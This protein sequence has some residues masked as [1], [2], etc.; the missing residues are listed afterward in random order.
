MKERPIIFSGAMVRA[1]LDGT[2]TQTRRVIKLRHSWSIEER[3]DGSPWP[4]HLDYVTGGEWDGWAPCPYGRPGDR[5]WVRETW[6]HTADS[7]EDARA[8]T[9]DV[10]SGTAVDY[11]ATYIEDCMREL[12]FS[13]KDAETSDR[14]ESWRPSIYMPRWAS[15]ILLEITEVRVQRLQDISEDDAQAEG[16]TNAECLECDGWRNAYSRLWESINGAGS[17]AANPWVWALTF[18]RVQP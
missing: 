15:R 6:R 14:F 5:L 18:R 17:W 2:K 3:D 4:W 1:L 11:R 13:R 12:N 10:A 7:L 16:I 9:D 8:I